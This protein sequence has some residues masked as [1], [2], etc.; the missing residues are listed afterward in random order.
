M[1]ASPVKT[2]RRPSSQLTSTPCLVQACAIAGPAAQAAADR[3]IEKTIV[4]V[5]IMPPSID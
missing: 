3:Q 2:P 1:I 4:R 5:M